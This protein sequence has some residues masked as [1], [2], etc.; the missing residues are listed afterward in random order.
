MNASFHAI[1]YVYINHTM[2][3]ARA[4]DKIHLYMD[5]VWGINVEACLYISQGIYAHL[6][7]KMLML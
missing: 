4:G 7:N 3:N 2:I 1:T 6:G 5:K